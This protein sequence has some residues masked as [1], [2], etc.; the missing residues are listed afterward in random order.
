MLILVYPFWA[1]MIILG[2]AMMGSG[3]TYTPAMVNA[4]VL[5]ILRVPLAWF[6][7][8]HTSLGVYGIFLAV[9]ATDGLGGVLML[10]VFRK[11]K[12]KKFKIKELSKTANL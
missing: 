12:W 6:L 4:F 10:H 7:S 5:I 11:G 3:D 2:R 1:F 8:M 9:I